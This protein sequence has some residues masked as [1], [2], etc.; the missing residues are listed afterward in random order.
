MIAVDGKVIQIPPRPFPAPAMTVA[1]PAARGPAG[2]PTTVVVG[3]AEPATTVPAGA[4]EFGD[5]AAASGSSGSSGIVISRGSGA[6]D[7][8]VF[9]PPSDLPLGGVFIDDGF[10][11]PFPQFPEDEFR[12]PRATVAGMSMWLAWLLGSIVVGGL[13]LFVA[14]RRVSLP[15]AKDSS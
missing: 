13:A 8:P 11:G 6:A 2:P 14:V 15:S 5:P 9:V 7:D 12:P 3:A 10:G 1:A 4:A